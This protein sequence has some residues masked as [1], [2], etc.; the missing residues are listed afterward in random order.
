MNQRILTF[1]NFRATAQALIVALLATLMVASTPVASSASINHGAIAYNSGTCELTAA[2]Y[3]G[4]GSPGDPYQISDSD[5]LWEVADCSLTGSPLAAAWFI[6]TNLISVSQASPGTPTTSPIGYSTSGPI[7]FS[8]ILI[9][10]AP[11]ING[12]AAITGLSISS[13]VGHAGLFVAMENARAENLRLFGQISTTH[14][15]SSAGGLA[16]VASGTTTLSYVINDAI[17][18]AHTTYPAAAGGLIGTLAGSAN[19]TIGI[20]QG[21]VSAADAGGLIGAIRGAAGASISVADSSNSGAG[22]FGSMNSSAGGFI[23]SI[24]SAATTVQ[25][26]GSSTNQAQVAAG[27][28]GG[29]VGFFSGNS[30][31]LVVDGVEN[32]STVSGSVNAGGL[33]GRASVGVTFS[34]VA[35]SGAVT[36]SGLSANVGGLLGELSGSGFIYTSSNEAVVSALEGPAGGLVGSASSVV[37]VAS[38]NSALVL[39]DDGYVGGL[40]GTAEYALVSNSVNS[41]PISS[42]GDSIGGLIGNAN[43]WATI[44]GSLNSGQIVGDD[45]VGGLIGFGSEIRIE[46]SRNSGSV[47]SVAGG[48]IGGIVG[49]AEDAA[50]I[51][52]VT[53]SGEVMGEEFVG[54]ILGGSWGTSRITRATNEAAVSGNASS[55]NNIGGLVGWSDGTLDISYSANFGAVSSTTSS[56]T[57]GVGGLVGGLF[58]S[59]TISASVNHG[60][61]L[62]AGESVGGLIGFID[63]VDTVTI[64]RVANTGNVTSTKTMDGQVGGFIGNL[65]VSAKVVVDNSYNAGDL[66]ADLAVGGMV[67]NQRGE[68]HLTNVYNA[69]TVTAVSADSPVAYSPNSAT[70]SLIAVYAL[71]YAAV[72]GGP[73]AT[74][75]TL[76]SRSTY[77]GWDFN[78]VWGFGTCSEN[79]GLPS[80]RVLGLFANYYSDGCYTAP[81]PS[82][83][84]S[85]GGSGAIY[86][87]PIITSM[88]SEVVVGELIEIEGRRLDSVATV[89][90]AGALQEVVS[91]S[92]TTLVVLLTASTTVGVAD[93]ILESSF[94][95]LT[96]Q[97]ALNVLAAEP[98]HPL[99][100]KTKVLALSEA[101]S[102]AWIET[103][104]ADSGLKR[105]VCTVTVAEG[106]TRAERVL[107][108]KSAKQTCSEV[109]LLL[110]A[111]SLWF[112]TKATKHSNFAGRTMLT[113][114]G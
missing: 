88:P 27:N 17:V 93:L 26:R 59:A 38:S 96:V 65:S 42:S 56:S 19:I 22:I 111:P 64:S 95:K 3:L 47:S 92:A 8:G 98:T 73:L 48:F 37:I 80:L 68:L 33:A 66:V 6:V 105:I 13:S 9:G 94:G 46:S 31:I 1:S 81:A 85:A 87:G 41:G 28:A 30:S 76:Q 7:S 45:N 24:E 23:G 49:W 70:T 114:K 112:Q 82:N 79:N 50:S 57:V 35:N 100:G 39:N 29:F 32:T 20:N 75:S 110:D 54:G 67:G 107:A 78:T 91:K 86:F 89:S 34:Q 58:D 108:R 10:Q 4:D 36:T 44:S 69:G 99:V 25:V 104:L 18:S 102:K 63:V 12:V 16:G 61:V 2:G 43:V 21:R 71:G 90:I 53:N 52:D 55:D 97:Q 106:A 60:N 74:I 15:G 11:G 72:A 113:F 83:P 109:A 103:N 5:S 77:T 101:K 62:S 84:G 14:N 40:L 51:E